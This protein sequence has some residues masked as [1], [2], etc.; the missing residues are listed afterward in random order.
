MATPLSFLPPTL[1]SANLKYANPLPLPSRDKPQDDSSGR[2][3][4]AERPAGQKYFDEPPNEY[5]TDYWTIYKKRLSE[6]FEFGFG[7]GFNSYREFPFEVSNIT[8][9]YTHGYWGSILPSEVDGELDNYFSLEGRYHAT[10]YGAL[11]LSLIIPFVYGLSRFRTYSREGS[12]FERADL[13]YVG[14]RSP[15]TLAYDEIYLE[16]TNLSR[17]LLGGAVTL[18]LPPLFIKKTRSATHYLIIPFIET[19]FFDPLEFDIF[20][21]KVQ[22]SYTVET[23]LKREKLGHISIDD[24]LRNITFGLEGFADRDGCE[25]SIALKYTFSSPTVEISNRHSTMPIQYTGD[26]YHQLGL[27]LNFYISLSDLFR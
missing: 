9:D 12:P 14:R 16:A 21:S 8:E 13:G 17:F 27:S 22:D 3:Q 7:L 6:F 24:R 15:Y 19:S 25:A 4:V 23:T 18:M 5:W 20:I 26:N 11:K 10:F 2:G 1:D